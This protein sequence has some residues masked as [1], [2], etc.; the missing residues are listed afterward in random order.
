MYQIAINKV[1]GGL[2]LLRLLSKWETSLLFVVSSTA[3][4]STSRTMGTKKSA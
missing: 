2:R 3:T 4:K 1:A